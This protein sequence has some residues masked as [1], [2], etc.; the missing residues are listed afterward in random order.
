MSKGNFQK[1]VL[2]SMVIT[3][4]AAA[5]SFGGGGGGGGALESTQS[6]NRKFLDNQVI[7]ATE[8]VR[9]AQ[10][11]LD[12]LYEMKNQ[13]DLDHKTI[14][15]GNAK[16]LQDSIAFMNKIAN[17]TFDI[18]KIMYTVGGAE[19]GYYR[20]YKDY[21][22]GIKIRD[23]KYNSIIARNQTLQ[24][25]YEQ[26][27]LS[28]QRRFKSIQAAMSIVDQDMNDYNNKSLALKKI[29]DQVTQNSTSYLP[30]MQAA[31]QILRINADSVGRLQLSLN[32]LTTLVS[33]IESERMKIS[34]MQEGQR[35]A[36]VQQ[37]MQ[38]LNQPMPNNYIPEV[39]NV[40][41]FKNTNIKVNSLKNLTKP[42]RTNTTTNTNKGVS[43]SDQ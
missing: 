19:Q 29:H 2:L 13:I 15:L 41:A 7:Q 37:I 23:P 21:I 40:Q 6:Q 33:T 42:S 32:N 5:A 20:H 16:E 1:S 14:G 8:A 30:M 39:S 12:K 43:P 9:K 34:D 28:R 17:S 26:N 38:K 31:V 3:V 22:D 11:Q 10:Q 4:A 24:D 18:N 25:M 27:V 36:T 35:A